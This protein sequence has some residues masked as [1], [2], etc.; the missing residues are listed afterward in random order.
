MGGSVEVKSKLGIGSQFIIKIKTKCKINILKEKIDPE[1][2][3]NDFK[4][5]QRKEGSEEFEY[6]AM[7][8]VQN[9]QIE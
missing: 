4:F 1:S 6:Y 8:L 9:L 7:L 3:L 5:I 2:N